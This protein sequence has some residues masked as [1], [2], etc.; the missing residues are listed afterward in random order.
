MVALDKHGHVSAWMGPYEVRALGEVAEKFF[1]TEINS[2]RERWEREHLIDRS[3]W[4]KAGDL[5][6]LCCAIPVEY[7]GGGGT[8]AH[9]FVVM[10]EQARANL[11]GW[12]GGQ[13]SVIDAHYVLAYGTEAQKRRWLPPMASGE[14]ISAIGM[15]EPGAGSDLKALAT[16]AMRQ[17]GGDYLISGSKTFISQGSSADLLILAA[18]TDA[19]AGARGI[20]LFLLDTNGLAGFSRGRVLRKSG[21]HYADTSEM[22][23]DE[24]RVPADWMLGER[25]NQGFSQLMDQLPQE[26]LTVGV[27]GAAMIE[28]A[29]E[30][31]V[32]YA[33]QR[34]MFGETLF[35]L[36]H[37]RFE[38]AEC[39]TLA[40][41]VRVFVDSCI[42]R[43]LAGT[44][45]TAT[46]S[47]A[48]YWVSDIQC[49]VI[50]RCLQLHGGYGYTQEYLIGQM[51]T[52]SRVTRIYGGAN[53]VQKEL[54]ARS[55]RS[56]GAP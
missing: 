19:D 17:P 8:L 56:H 24:V 16:R 18:K 54:I 15:T 41:V 2:E 47:M 40:Q 7:G 20:S 37:P 28:K 52:D 13:H 44:L 11:L 1:A 30:E 32:A 31:T 48:K 25:E 38:L 55:L 49:Q 33:L 23:F 10:H 46:A 3:V 21:Q 4:R 42:D 9:D 22:F 53:E 29:V 6:L 43:C 39:A 45:D 5:G 14:A 50:D 34:R 12:G 27:A 35:D 26:R 51:W 36:Q